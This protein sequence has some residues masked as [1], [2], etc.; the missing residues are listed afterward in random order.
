[1]KKIL[2]CIFLISCTAIG[3]GMLAL[4]CAVYKNG[5]ILSVMIFILCWLFMTIGALSLLEV[6]FWFKKNTNIIIMVE[7]FFGYKL[8]FFISIIY[9]SLLYALESAYITAYSKWSSYLNINSDII[10]LFMFIL[11]IF[12]ILFYKNEAINKINYV[13]SFLLF[14]IYIILFSLCLKS[15]K[16]NSIITFNIQDFFGALSLIVTSFGFAIIIPSLS[17]YLNKNFNYI[18]KSLLIGSLIPLIIYIFWIF[19]VI[20]IFP[21]Y[22][23][24]SIENLINNNENFDINFIYFI[25]RITN[26]NYI[27]ILII[28][29]S[30]VSILTSII[31]VS[32][33]LKDLL[34]DS[35]NLKKSNI[36]LLFLIVIPPIIFTKYSSFGFTYILKISGI[37][38]SI[39]LGLLPITMLYYGK[40]VLN[41]KSKYNFLISKKSLFISYIFFIFIIFNDLM[42]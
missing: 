11:L 15:I 19:I 1:M 17:S 35:L 3:A 36:I 5:I 7:N 2:N 4:P 14:F 10:C 21:R 30:I 27:S 37:L 25:K 41:I 31:G 40:Y 18:Y 6:T 38:V 24:N 33:S 42:I 26:I 34:S 22:G 29:F 13:L 23:L 16:N 9:L 39:L 8:K 20:S 28:S 32:I 12:F